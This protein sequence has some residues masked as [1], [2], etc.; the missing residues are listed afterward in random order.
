MNFDAPSASPSAA[1]GTYLTPSASHGFNAT[2]NSASGPPPASHKSLAQFIADLQRNIRDA[3]EPAQAPQNATQQQP[4][5]QSEYDATLLHPLAVPTGSQSSTP[6]GSALQLPWPL[7]TSALG[8][9]E[10]QI[11][12]T[13]LAGQNIGAANQLVSPASNVS[14][15][16]RIR[17]LALMRETGALTLADLATEE[18]VQRSKKVIERRKDYKVGFPGNFA[19]K[20]TVKEVLESIAKDAGWETFQ[21]ADDAGGSG[22]PS[23]MDTD[24]LQGGNSGSI[25]HTITMAGKGVVL[26]VDFELPASKSATPGQ[27]GITASSKHA[28]G[29]ITAVRFS[30]GLEGSTDPGVD[31]LLSKQAKAADWAA[32]R[33]SI[34]ILA[35]LDD[36]TGL[37]ES[38][39]RDE[40]AVGGT[41][42][43]ENASNGDPDPLSAMKALSVKLEEVFKSEL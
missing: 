2:P 34:L 10:Y 32:M 29:T 4:A 13:G 22:D 40:E 41:N 25:S 31:K 14:D 38:M 15:K 26:D 18:G 16:D 8:S 6:A 19:G 17:L 36:V 37:Q 33:E 21:G 3:F 39:S 20:L 23:G 35:R 24:D 5:P 30:Y 42:A 28:F 7:I 12:N 9:F 27:N 43:D 1:G 11:L